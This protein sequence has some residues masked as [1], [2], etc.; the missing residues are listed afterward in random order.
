MTNSAADFAAAAL[1]ALLHPIGV[2]PLDEDRVRYACAWAWY[3]GHVM[4]EMNPDTETLGEAF[5]TEHS[6]PRSEE[7]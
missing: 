4:D 7:T 6:P 2:A 1:T 5:W 3:I